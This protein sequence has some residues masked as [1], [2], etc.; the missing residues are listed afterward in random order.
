MQNQRK[1]FALLIGDIVRFSD[2]MEQDISKA[3]S[4]LE[5]YQQAIDI[6]LIR[7]QGQLQNNHFGN[8]CLV[9]FD[10]LENALQSAISLHKQFQDQE[11][12]QVSIL[13]TDKLTQNI[14]L[15]SRPNQIF[16]SSS[17]KHLIAANKNLEIRS[18]PKSTSQANSDILSLNLLEQDR[19][20][21][22]QKLKSNSWLAIAVVLLLVAAGTTIITD[23][24][25]PSNNIDHTSNIIASKKSIAVLPFTNLS[26]SEQSF[27]ADGVMEDILT[28]LAKLEGLKVISRTSSTQYKSTGKT[29]PEIAAEL[30]V[31]Y[32]L[33]GSVRQYND[34]VKITV[35][36]IKSIEDEHIWAGTY[37]RKLE[38]IF[39]IQSEV[40]KQI[41]NQLNQ[42]IS[43]E[44][45]QNI[46]RPPT[47]N[48]AAYNA[49][50]E[51]RELNRIR[52][53]ASMEESLKR[54]DYALQLDPDFVDALAEKAT[55]INVMSSLGYTS[56]PIKA[57]EQAERLALEAIKID[58]TNHIAY[59]A[60]GNLYFDANKW[61][62]A[63]TAFQIA[64][65][66]NPNDALAN[67]W[68]SLKLRYVGRLE[69]AIHYGSIA[70][71][72]DPLYPVIQTGHALTCM[73][74]D[75]MDLAKSIIDKN[76]LTFENYFGYY[77]IS[78]YYYM[79]HQQY[80]LAIADFNKSQKLSPAITSIERQI[81]YC[82]GRMG[83]IE[84][85]K[86]YIASQTKE[87]S[88]TYINLAS[89]YAGI[90]EKQKC[91]NY[92]RKAWNKGGFSTGAMYNVK[93]KSL[94]DEPD[95]QALLAEMK[96]AEAN[97]Q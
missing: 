76:E 90:D 74:G 68:Y 25:Q 28:H 49:L 2:W 7:F 94:L 31:Q 79:C 33:E 51:S 30:G 34:Q 26:D 97:I 18:L 80:E 45:S 87:D 72:L 15:S 32:I 46:D 13:L 85:V 39:T 84:N 21:V 4:L 52:T 41:A 16:I 11:A 86:A 5:K 10:R 53:K 81:M 56:D 64:I 61:G 14:D 71:E 20:P 66:H 58:P 96:E 44:L 88:E 67:Y 57:N 9:Y 43:P 55:T 38:D 62:Q 17:L 8:T 59:A 42:T 60:L 77:W 6:S 48:I 65:Q 63:E 92:I 78:A 83:Q 82:K 36:L 89:A 40:S 3:L 22:F 1:R 35:Q 95:Y 12:L 47:N 19:H 75:R 54:L 93:F 29:I 50:L 27:F 23:Q 70:A 91:I 69:E 73:M 37:E 24:F